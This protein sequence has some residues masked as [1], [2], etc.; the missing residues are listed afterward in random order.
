MLKR[1]VCHFTKQDKTS[2]IFFF[3]V[4]FLI[5]YLLF[6]YADC[7]KVF[8]YGFIENSTEESDSKFEKGKEVLLY[9]DESRRKL[10]SRFTIL[11]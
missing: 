9:A 1:G 10:N 8:H 2:E 5:F 3:F 7:S 6:C 4:V 11:K